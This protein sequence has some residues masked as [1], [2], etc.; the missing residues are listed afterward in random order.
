MR[1][2]D[3]VSI[4]LFLATLEEGSIAKAA[5]REN[6]VPSAIS[7][8]M[9]ELEA[10]F[11]VPLLERGLKGVTA[12]P[13]GEA[14]RQHARL[15]LQTVDRMHREMAGYVDGVR[16]HVRVM[17]SVTSLAGELPAD[18]Q[19]FRSAHPQIEIDLEERMTPAIFRAVQEGLADVGVA[20][21]FGSH[22][23]LQVFA[24]RSY[25]LT[26]V[27]P[28][29]HPLAGQSSL[30]YAQ[31]LPFDQIELNRDSGIARVFEA[32]AR[33]A[34]LPKRTRVHVNAYETICTLVGRG[35]GVGVVPHY[36]KESQER[37]TGIRFIPLSDSWSHPDIFVAVRDIEAL[38][39]AAQAL[40]TH[41]K[42]RA[43]SKRD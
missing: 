13:A 39:A 33:D 27:V 17:A 26:A 37:T 4:R 1:D 41:L 6:I 20:S 29:R 15:W 10:I 25:E 3:P 21:E 40:V 2:I 18:I 11:N 32:A 22:E 31:L 30:T 38:P 5:A 9:S 19:A 8:R 34:K 12:T 36:L 35:M 16:G 7:K 14:F 23:G 43:I 42:V 28:A 24:Y